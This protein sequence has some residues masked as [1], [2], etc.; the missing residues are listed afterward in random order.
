MEGTARA[1]AA[2]CSS[3]HSRKS[4]LWR[5]IWIGDYPADGQ[6]GRLSALHHAL[7]QFGFG[8][9]GNMIGDMSGLSARQIRAPVFGQIQFA[10]DEGMAQGGHVGE[11]VE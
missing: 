4:G 10:V 6:M 8:G 7:R 9:K 1:Y 11:Y 3:S 2:S 5:E